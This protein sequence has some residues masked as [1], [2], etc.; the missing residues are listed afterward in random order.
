VRVGVDIDGVLCDHVVGLARWVKARYGI[1]FEKNQVVEWD[2]NFGAGTL[3]EALREAYHDDAFVES[4]PTIDGA[5]SGLRGLRS[6]SHVQVIS[7]RP[8]YARE[9]TRRWIGTHF[10]ATSLLFVDG[11]KDYSPVDILVDDY[12]RNIEGFT[13]RGGIGV[14]FDQPWNRGFR[15]YDRELRH[16]GA[17][18]AGDWP[19]VLQLVHRQLNKGRR[20]TVAQ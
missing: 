2:Y 14:L 5:V 7:N 10:G 15:L 3:V 19:E 17:V 6:S 16:G 13:Q 18:R 1:D 9:A 20:T 8:A 12:P 4:L 11:Y